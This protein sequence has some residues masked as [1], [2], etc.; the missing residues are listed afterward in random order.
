LGEADSLAGTIL[1]LSARLGLSRFGDDGISLQTFEASIAYISFFNPKTFIMEMVAKESVR[2]GFLRTIRSTTP[3]YALWSA[4]IDSQVVV[5]TS[6]RRFYIVGVNVTKVGTLAVYNP[7]V[8]YS[9]HYNPS[10][11]I[12]HIQTISNKPK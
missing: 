6:R 12:L 11:T 7:I 3:Q 1:A 4:V 9:S 5:P 2:Q 8:A 10:R